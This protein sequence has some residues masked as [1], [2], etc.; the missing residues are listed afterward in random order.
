MVFLSLFMLTLEY[1]A[2]HPNILILASGATSS[3]C[4]IRTIKL[5]H[6]H[7]QNN[8]PVWILTTQEVIMH[9]IL[10]PHSVAQVYDSIAFSYLPPVRSMRMNISM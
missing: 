10:K 1:I 5:E 9:Y 2:F 4:R 8:L 7:P 6:N 3:Y